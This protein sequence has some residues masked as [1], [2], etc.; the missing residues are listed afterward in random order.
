MELDNADTGKNHKSMP[1]SDKDRTS[2]AQ[3]HLEVSG[4]K[5]KLFSQVVCRIQDCMH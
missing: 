3:I 5:P 1:V 2:R 4:I